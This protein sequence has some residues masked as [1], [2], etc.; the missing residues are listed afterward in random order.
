MG[1]TKMSR[2]YRKHPETG[3]PSPA[4]IETAVS[5]RLTPEDYVTIREVAELEDRSVSSLVRLLIRRACIAHRASLP[6]K[7]DTTPADG[8]LHA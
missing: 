4:K 2:E 6:P 7:P 8:H 5:L 3:T 1:Q